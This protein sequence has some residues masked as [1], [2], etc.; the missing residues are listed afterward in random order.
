M[1]WLDRVRR[2][3]RPPQ[4]D[5]P[6]SEEER[7]ELDEPQSSFGVRAEFEREYA[8]DDFDPDEPR[9]GRL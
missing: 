3:W 9:S 2:F 8:G 5:H 4:P 6:L 1:S 7:H